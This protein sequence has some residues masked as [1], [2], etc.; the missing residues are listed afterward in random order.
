[1]QGRETRARST[2]PAYRTGKCRMERRLAPTRPSHRIDFGPTH[3]TRS[4]HRHRGRGTR[5]A[6]PRSS[7]RGQCRGPRVQWWCL[8]PA[9]AGRPRWKTFHFAEVPNHGASGG[10]DR[11]GGR[12]LP[13]TRPRSHHRLRSLAASD[14]PRRTAATLERASRRHVACGASAGSPRVGRSRRPALD[15]GPLGA[16]G[17]DRSGKPR[18]P[19]RV[20]SPRRLDLAPSDLPG[21]DPAGQA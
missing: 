10:L 20:R 21:R 18:I 6:R 13:A 8:V 14:P 1:M 2:V 5:A 16:A 12:L 19:R 7:G 17:P 3:P 9:D 4:G 11:S 15:R